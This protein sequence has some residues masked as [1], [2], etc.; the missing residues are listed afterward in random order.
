MNKLTKKGK[1]KALRLLK[2]EWYKGYKW[3]SKML[4]YSNPLKYD[5]PELSRL[6]DGWKISISSKGKKFHPIAMYVIFLWVLD[7]WMYGT[8]IDFA[9]GYFNWFQHKSVIVP[10][11]AFN[12]THF[13]K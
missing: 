4:V 1:R 3:W 12:D 5:V 6:E 10:L 9:F 11:D 8:G 7:V 2:K 13:K